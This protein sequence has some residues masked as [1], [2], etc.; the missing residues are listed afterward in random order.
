M[1]LSEIRSGD[2]FRTT[3]DEL[4]V[5]TK[6]SLEDLNFALGM[7]GIFIDVPSGVCLEKPIYIVHRSDCHEGLCQPK[8][9]MRL[10]KNAQA[11][12]I[13]DFRGR[14]REDVFYEFVCRSGSRGGRVIGA[15]QVTA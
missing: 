6:D 1:I 11:V 7:D 10:G 3:L 15:L 14:G 2:R 9:I 13:E 5:F 4:N 8:T 12:L